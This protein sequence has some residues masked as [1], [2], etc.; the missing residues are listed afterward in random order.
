MSCK[1]AFP[2][3]NVLPGTWSNVRGASIVLPYPTASDSLR[4][5]NRFALRRAWNTSILATNTRRPAIGSFRVV[6]NA[7]DYLSR[8]SYSSGGANMVTSRPGVLNMTLKDGGQKNNSDGTGIPASTCN[9][10]YVYDSSDFTKYRRQ[11]EINFGYSGL[12]KNSN[13][14]YSA[15]GSNN[16][17][18]VRLK[19]VRS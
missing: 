9:T 2:Y 7:G 5:L 16:G 12:G 6:Y 19:F 18:Y 1:T 11:K 15:G 17:S 14:D 8:V 13:A 10:K 3:K 4:Q